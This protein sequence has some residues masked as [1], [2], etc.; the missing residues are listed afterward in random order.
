MVMAF[1]ARRPPSLIV[2]GDAELQPYLQRKFLQSLVLEFNHLHLN[3]LDDPNYRDADGNDNSGSPSTSPHDEILTTFYPS[4]GV[5][6][7]T[8]AAS[9]QDVAGSLLTLTPTASF[10]ASGMTESAHLASDPNNPSTSSTT[11]TTTTAAATTNQNLPSLRPRG[12]PSSS[13]N[14][15]LPRRV[16]FVVAPR[17]RPRTTAS[18]RCRQKENHRHTKQT[19]PD[20]KSWLFTMPKP[21][22]SLGAIPDMTMGS[23]PLRD[24][25]L[26]STMS[27]EAV[28]AAT[29]VSP[30]VAADPIQ[31]YGTIQPESVFNELS[32]DRDGE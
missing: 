6:S 31:E 22:L 12:R 27:Y 1:M 24:L 4:A 25:A 26:A 18:R 5:S 3:D 10:L 28:L 30:S 2:L 29:M 20:V 19:I 7:G 17:N 14:I 21:R 9:S 13:L 32:A 15:R 16:A 23:V 8:G 11:P